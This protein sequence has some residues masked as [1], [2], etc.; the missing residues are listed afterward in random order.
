[1]TNWTPASQSSNFVNCSYDTISRRLRPEAAFCLNYRLFL[2]QQLIRHLKGNFACFRTILKRQIWPDYGNPN[3]WLPPMR[4]VEDVVV[5]VHA[6]ESIAT[7]RTGVMESLFKRVT[8]LLWID[9]PNMLIN[10]LCFLL[11][12]AVFMIEWIPSTSHEAISDTFCS[13]W[14]LFEVK[15]TPWKSTGRNAVVYFQY[16]FFSWGFQISFRLFKAKFLPQIYV[17]GKFSKEN[18]KGTRSNVLT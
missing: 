9:Q 11:F 10:K 7:Q 1:M 4:N 18:W 8:F 6:T 15:F 3:S 13:S 12:Y 16:T 14:Q 5:Y 17:K 2:V